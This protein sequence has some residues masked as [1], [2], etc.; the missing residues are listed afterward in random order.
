MRYAHGGISERTLYSQ[1][2]YLDQTSSVYCLLLITSKPEPQTRT[3]IGTNKRNPKTTEMG[4]WRVASKQSKVTVHH[5]ACTGLLQIPLEQGRA[6]VRDE[7]SLS[8][9]AADC[10]VRGSEEPNLSSVNNNST[11]ILEIHRLTVNTHNWGNQNNLVNVQL[12]MLIVIFVYCKNKC[13]T[14]IRITPR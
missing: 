9:Q 12:V 2:L 14:T 6:P 8:S 13:R 10:T 5:V 1:Q 3:N 11:S 7:R 4:Q